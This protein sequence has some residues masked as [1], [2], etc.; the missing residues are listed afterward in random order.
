MR[1]YDMEKNIPIYKIIEKDLRLAILEGDLKQNE[2]IPSETEL[3]A[4]YKV[5]RMTVRQ[6]INNLLVD[7]Y[8]YRHKGKG[9]FVIFNKT[10]M[11]QSPS[12]PSF[13][14]HREMIGVKS[15]IKNV[16]L[17][18]RT[19]HS[20]EII[21]KGL[22]IPLG[23]EIIYVE[24]VR[25]ADNIPLVY[26]R[27]Y[28]PKDLYSHLPLEAFEGS[29]HTYIQ[30]YLN[31]KIKNSNRSIEAR[32]VNEQV[33]IMLHQSVGEPSLYMSSISYLENGRAFLYSRQYFHGN[34]FR[35]RH[36]FSK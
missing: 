3:A 26:E 9:T 5:T 23:S 12:E 21:S 6:A 18:F 1:E 11:E 33:A 7:G 24:R 35:F 4:K 20:D 16:V 22:G 27:L 14:F 19:E 2:M 29:F 34:H 17:N 25:Q 10:E 30:E 13:S 32:A 28:L 8:I 31:Y 15:P 36:N